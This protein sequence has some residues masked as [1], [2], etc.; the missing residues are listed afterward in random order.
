MEQYSTYQ[1]QCLDGRKSTQEIS[2]RTTVKILAHCPATSSQ[3]LRRAYAVTQ[4]QHLKRLQKD[5]KL[6]EEQYLIYL[7]ELHRYVEHGNDSQVS[8]V[9]G[10]YQK[11]S[12][13]LMLISYLMEW[14][15]EST[16]P[17]EKRLLGML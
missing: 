15:G 9:S 14:D 2:V 13:D 8:N 4:V 3:D 1:D 17:S 5:G 16:D 7:R 12:I 6:E 11:A 10:V